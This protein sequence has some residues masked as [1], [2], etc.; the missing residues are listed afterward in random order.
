M[1]QFVWVAGTL[2]LVLI[3]SR[4]DP[5]DKAGN[6]KAD[7]ESNAKSAAQFLAP[8]KEVEDSRVTITVELDESLVNSKDVWLGV[9][10]LSA[11]S[12][13]WLQDAPLIRGGT[14][15]RVVNLGTKGVP[16]EED[17]EV[18]ILSFPKGKIK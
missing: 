5:A 16:T 2:A 12:T 7:K 6:K 9:M 1:R 11:P 8:P 15:K 14:Q 18:V 4:A 3:S 13:I 17:Y 10:P